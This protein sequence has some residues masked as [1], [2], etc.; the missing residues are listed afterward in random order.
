MCTNWEQVFSGGILNG[1]KA[2]FRFLEDQSAAFLLEGLITVNAQSLKSTTEGLPVTLEQA[3][4]DQALS[5]ADRDIFD[6]ILGT[7]N[8]ILAVR[9]QVELVGILLQEKI[10]SLVGLCAEAERTVQM[11]NEPS[12]YTALDAL[13]DLWNAARALGETL[14]G[15]ATSFSYYTVTQR[16]TVGQAAAAI[17][18]FGFTVTATDL[19]QL[20]P[21]DNAFDIPAGTRLRYLAGAQ[22]L[23]A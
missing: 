11:F 22:S 2:T 14:T 17:S 5:Q 21:I 15:P 16:M 7:A 9:D 1:E 20:N 4:A 6:A 18:S 23:A 8:E 13:K 19:L 10:G 12:N 3:L